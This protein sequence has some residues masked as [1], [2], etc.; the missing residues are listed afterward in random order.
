MTFK[1]EFQPTFVLIGEK[2]IHGNT[3]MGTKQPERWTFIWG[4][5]LNY[6]HLQ[7]DRGG[8]RK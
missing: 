2:K 8:I 4:K 7:G 6:F 1:K 5:I 3:I